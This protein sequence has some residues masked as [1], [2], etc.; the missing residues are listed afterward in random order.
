MSLFHGPATV[1]SGLILYLD[2][3]NPKSYTGSGTQWSDLS[4]LANQ[5]SMVNTP[6]YS[7]SGPSRFAF[8]GSNQY[9]TVANYATS[10]AFTTSTPFSILTWI[11]LSSINSNYKA[12]VN[13]SNSTGAWN[14]GL[15][16]SNTNKIYT[17]YNN[18]GYEAGPALSAAVWYHATLTYA[19]STH[20]L[21]LNSSFQGSTS[22]GID[23]SASQTLA[24][25]R[26]G[27][28][29]ADYFLGDIAEVQIYN[30]ALSAQ[31]IIQ[32]YNATRGRYGL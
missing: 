17:G 3:A 32:N 24:I 10:F 6:T 7:A 23:S 31:E 19:S 27:A 4:G 8:N 12:V 29:S 1:L 30:R 21:Y 16:V 13:S 14:Y 22:L 26:K 5:A 9:A 20:S 2:A 28:T 11:R 18:N 25:G 15:Y